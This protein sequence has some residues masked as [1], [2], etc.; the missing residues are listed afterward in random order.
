[1]KRLVV[2]SRDSRLAIAQS[3]SLVQYLKEALPETEIELVT[4]K[5]SGDRKLDR[6][7]FEIGGKG[8]F[9]KELDTALREK[10]VDITVHSL[11]DVPLVVP[12]DLPLLGFSKRE[13]PRDVLVLP[14]G[15]EEGCR[16]D[17]IGTSSLRRGLQLKKIYPDISVKPIRGNIETRLRKLDAGEYGALVLAAA[18]LLRLGLEKRISRYYSVEEIIPAAGQGILAVQGREGEDYSFLQGYLD[19]A[20]ER[21]AVCERAFTAEL[22]ADCT[23]PV[24][25]HAVIREGVLCLTGLYFEEE[26]GKYL[27]GTIKGPAEDGSLLGAELA[28]KLR[29]R[30]GREKKL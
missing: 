27:T 5:T 7:L 13:E 29:E 4:M 20:A 22:G 3:M 25:A 8:L 11:K 17:T 19:P 30:S 26:T 1:M 12:S 14:E 18:G 23:S 15:K 6:A 24:C 9:V 2:G 16:F 21:E 28:R 10:R